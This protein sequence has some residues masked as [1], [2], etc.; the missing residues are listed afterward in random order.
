MSSLDKM[1]RSEL[2][3]KSMELQAGAAAVLRAEIARR[4]RQVAEDQSH[5]DRSE[6][7]EWNRVGLRGR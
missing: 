4:D 5:A 3:R 1:T 6:S 2:I 7:N